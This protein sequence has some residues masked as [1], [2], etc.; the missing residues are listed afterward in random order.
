MR[1]VVVAEWYPSRFDPVHGVWAHRQALAA[2]DAGAD[3]RVLALRRPVPPLSAVR[4][5]ELGRWLAGVRGT[6]TSIELDGIAVEAVPLVAPPRSWSYGT[7]GYWAA[8]SVAMALN[9][10]WRRWRFDV[11]H[12][13]SLLPAGFAAGWWR[14]HFRSPQ[15]PAV[16]ASTHGPDIIYVHRRSALSS[17]ATAATLRGVDL[18]VANS[19]WAAKRAEELANGPLETRLVHFGTDL[20]AEEPRRHTRPTLATVAHLQSRKRHAVVLHALSELAAEQRPD[21]VII[22]D[23]PGREPLSAL[24]RELGVGDRVRFTGQLPH[25]QAVTEAWRCHLYV[26][27]SVEEPFGVAYVEA[28]AGGLPAVGCEGEGGPE[29]IAAAGEGMLLVQPDDHRALAGLLKSL[30]S[31]PKRLAALGHAARMTVG[32]SFTWRHCGEATVGAYR[33][34]IDMAAGRLAAGRAE[35][36]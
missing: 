20:P 3:V 33:A 1:V 22:G 16:V 13:H 2:R 32:R 4:R 24:A 15:A 35:F 25:A 29:D 19:S 23:G 36:D 11:L 12:A 34:A 7:W 31:D 9:R 5:G 30:V 21:Y 14:R 28:M 17:R 18:V 27:P 6:L 8:P 10:L 26:M